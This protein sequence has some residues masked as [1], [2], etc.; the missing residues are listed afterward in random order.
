MPNVIV[1]PP[2][3]TGKASII[4]LNRRSTRR[5]IFYILLGLTLGAVGAHNFYAGFKSTA[6]TQLLISLLS[7][8]T[9]L[10]FVALWAAHEAAHINRDA[11]GYTME[12]F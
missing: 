8:G 11:D 2:K 1:V 6:I 10:P 3:Y 7:L 5:R 4:I 9:L 12:L